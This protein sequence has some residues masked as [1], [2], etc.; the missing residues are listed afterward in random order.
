MTPADGGFR[1]VMRLNVVVSV[2]GGSARRRN[3]RLDCRT[4]VSA[5]N[6]GSDRNRFHFVSTT[7]SR[8]AG[9]ATG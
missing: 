8:M 7:S 4:V 2:D 5:M 9:G 3:V 1:H 6:A